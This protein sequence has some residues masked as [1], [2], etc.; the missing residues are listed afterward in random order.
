MLSELW[1]PAGVY[2]GPRRD[3]GDKEEYYGIIEM[4]KTGLYFVYILASKTNGT[5]YIGMTNNL[6]KRVDQHKK[7]LTKG[8]TQKYGVHRLV[9]FEQFRDVCYAINREK[10]MKE[11]QRQWKINLIEKNNPNWEDLFDHLVETRPWA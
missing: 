9:Y 4:S 2:P 8:F 7:N 11:W 5:L 10:R 3:R 6:I 1:T